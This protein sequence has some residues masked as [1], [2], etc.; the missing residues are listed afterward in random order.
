MNRVIHRGWGEDF[1]KILLDLSIHIFHF[2]S[3]TLAYALG[4][5]LRRSMSRPRKQHIGL[6]EI[7]WLAQ[8]DKPIT[9]RGIAERNWRDRIDPVWIVDLAGL[10]STKQTKQTR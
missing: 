2:S 5:H 4:N 10:N 7:R 6:A 3:S 1:V 9:P 8:R